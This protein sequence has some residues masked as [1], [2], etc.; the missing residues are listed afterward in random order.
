MT[1]I[2]GLA[3]FFLVALRLAVGWHFLVEGGHKLK[4]HYEGKTSWNDPWT[5]EG[6][7]K[8]G[9]GPAAPY[10]RQSLHLDD[11]DALARLKAE[12]HRLPDAVNAE[13]DDYFARFAAH[14]DLS[15]QQRIEAPAKLGKA[16]QD[17]ANWLAGEF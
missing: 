17:T 11:R 3:C 4:T 14:Y 8:E 2:S 13:W 10:A 15:E 16:K 5:G 1:R 12:E 9:I 7:F 6:F